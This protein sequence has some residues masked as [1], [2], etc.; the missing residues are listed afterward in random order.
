MKCST[1]GAALGKEPHNNLCRNVKES[2]PV[3][4]FKTK[5]EETGN[6]KCSRAVC[7]VILQ[8]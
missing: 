1:K 6:F 2:Q 8:M 7:P 4:Q 5:L 3:E